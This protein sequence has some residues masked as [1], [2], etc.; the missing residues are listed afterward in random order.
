MY[1]AAREAM[2]LGENSRAMLLFRRVA[3]DYPYTGYA[4]LALYYRAFLQYREYRPGSLAELRMALSTLRHLRRTYPNSP[5]IADARTLETRVCG[6]LAQ[7]GDTAC[8][9]QVVVTMLASTP[10][11]YDARQSSRMWSS[12]SPQPRQDSDSV[13]AANDASFDNDQQLDQS[14]AAVDSMWKVGRLK[15]M[16]VTGQVLFSENPCLCRLR[17]QAIFLLTQQAAP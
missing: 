11:R 2:I 14:I 1:R 4:P 13:S 15:P 16:R 9:T 12:V 8:R 10:V 17:E 3:Q 7:A 6:E 5:Q